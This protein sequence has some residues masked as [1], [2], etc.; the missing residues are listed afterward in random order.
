MRKVI[1]LIVFIS[2]Q[3][4]C[5]TQVNVSEK[6]AEIYFGT[7]YGEKSPDS[8]SLKLENTLIYKNYKLYSVKSYGKANGEIK[9]FKIK[10][11]LFS[12]NT[13]D[14]LVYLG[15]IRKKGLELQIIYREKEINYIIDINQGKYIIFDAKNEEILMT[16]I[17]R[18]PV[19][20]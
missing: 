17:N 13:E 9:I 12:F 8:I 16:Q 6:Y 2:V 4:I 7:G 11:R 3:S 20:M 1:P 14:N 5:F 15:K 19:F 18:E 10:N